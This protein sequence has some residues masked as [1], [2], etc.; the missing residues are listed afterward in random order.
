VT[1][2]PDWKLKV[3]CAVNSVRI[4]SFDIFRCVPTAMERTAANGFRLTR[5]RYSVLRCTRVLPPTEASAPVVFRSYTK[6]HLFGTDKHLLLFLRLSLYRCE[7]PG[8][9]CAICMTVSSSTR[10]YGPSWVAGRNKSL[11]AVHLGS[12]LCHPWRD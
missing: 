11:L 1:S 6:R 7:R 3:S 9:S 12:R 2:S 4:R 10:H 8:S 5:Q